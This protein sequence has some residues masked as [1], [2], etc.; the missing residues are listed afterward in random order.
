MK[1]VRFRI[2]ILVSWVV[3]LSIM[4]RLLDPIATIHLK[5]EMVFVAAVAALAIPRWPKYMFWAAIGALI[6]VAVLMKY[7]IGDLSGNLAM[8]MTV[9]EIFAVIITTLLARW[10]GNALSDF[11]K[12]VA[13]ITM[14][15]Q[16]NRLVTALSGQGSIYREVRRARNHMHPLALIS[17]SVDE[18]SIDPTTE[19]LVREVQRSMIKEYKLQNLSRILCAE[20]EDSAV[21]VQETDRYLAVLPDTTPDELAVVVKRLRLKASG[22]VGVEIKVGTAI[23]PND[24]YTF[25]GLVERAT[26][27]MENDLEQELDVL[28]EQYPMERRI[29]E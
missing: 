7:W 11:E 13:E 9:V 3:F 10:V 4:S 19:K 20:L 25:E 17:I 26:Q 1:S 21:I 24:S 23:L 29:A 16:D 22:Q 18:N 2:I 15:R 14:G 6:T 8:L 27:E 28:K 12:A 5:I